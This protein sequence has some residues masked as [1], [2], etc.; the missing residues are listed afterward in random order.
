M[1]IDHTHDFPIRT[2]LRLN[3]SE[4]VRDVVRSTVRHYRFHLAADQGGIDLL[5]MSNALLFH[6]PS[7]AARTATLEE[8]PTIRTECDRR[9]RVGC[10]RL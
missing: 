4:V 5:R 10:G 6:C 2:E 1:S 9:V 3:V 8:Y 7:R